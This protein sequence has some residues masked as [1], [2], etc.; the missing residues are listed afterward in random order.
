MDSRHGRNLDT[1]LFK[2]HL[3]FLWQ[4]FW[5]EGDQSKT[6]ST[7]FEVID[8]LRTQKGVGEEEKTP[9]ENEQKKTLGGRREEGC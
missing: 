1:N 6:A 5:V 2:L 9:K 3:V 8:Q 4:V 7:I